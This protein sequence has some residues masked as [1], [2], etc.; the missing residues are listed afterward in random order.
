[1]KNAFS[2]HT[3]KENVQKH[4]LKCEAEY[5]NG[6]LIISLWKY[7]RDAFPGPLAIVVNFTCIPEWRCHRRQSLLKAFSVAFIPI[8]ENKVVRFVA[9]FFNK[10][11]KIA[12]L[13][14]W[15]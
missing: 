15:I 13:V 3:L 14:V 2:C 7:I 8:A 9:I 6:T 11:H 5:T 12:T 10:H 4:R 1:M